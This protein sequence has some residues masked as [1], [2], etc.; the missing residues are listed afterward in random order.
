MVCVPG[1]LVYTRV[2]SSGLNMCESET[3]GVVQAGSVVAA[4]VLVCRQQGKAPQP[5]RMKEI[6]KVN[7]TC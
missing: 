3:L 4:G 6:G 1:A 7:S 2:K 5:E